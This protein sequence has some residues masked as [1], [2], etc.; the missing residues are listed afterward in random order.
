MVLMEQLIFCLTKKM[1]FKSQGKFLVL[2]LTQY[3]LFTFMRVVIWVMVVIQLVH[4]LILLVKTMDQ[5]IH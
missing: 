4:I 2:N 1:K 5:E 3:M